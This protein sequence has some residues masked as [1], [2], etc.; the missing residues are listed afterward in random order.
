[1]SEFSL[2]EMSLD[3]RVY[4]FFEM[5]NYLSCLAFCFLSAGA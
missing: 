5:E 3:M 1:M 2:K 4:H